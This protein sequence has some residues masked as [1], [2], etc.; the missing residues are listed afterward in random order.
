MSEA[1]EIV[2]KGFAIL[3]FIRQIAGK[4]EQYRL[5]SDLLK[6]DIY[7]CAKE[8]GTAIVL[9]PKCDCERCTKAKEL[10]KLYA[11]EKLTREELETQL[12]EFSDDL[13]KYHAQLSDL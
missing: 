9:I 7:I 8:T 13:D 2:I 11:E 12:D 5:F 4:N 10:M 3:K 6:S 1:E